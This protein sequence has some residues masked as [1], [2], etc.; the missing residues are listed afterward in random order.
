MSNN[1]IIGLV[2]LVGG[3]TSFVVGVKIQ[4]YRYNKR[5]MEFMKMKEELDKIGFRIL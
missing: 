5:V 1:L 4:E 2:F 3:I